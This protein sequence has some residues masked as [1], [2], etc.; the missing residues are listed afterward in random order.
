M[1]CI[2]LRRVGAQKCSD[3]ID[4]CPRVDGLGYVA[5]TAGGYCLLS[6]ARHRESSQ[7]DNWS[8][9]CGGLCLDLSGQCQSVIAG[10]LNVHQDEVGCVKAEAVKSRNGRIGY[11]ND[12]AVALEDCAREHLI[13][14]IVLDNQDAP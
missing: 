10:K 11:F 5:A 8:R 1:G 4:K 3:L 12:K 7:R 6:I 9:G 2:G 14:W 13:L